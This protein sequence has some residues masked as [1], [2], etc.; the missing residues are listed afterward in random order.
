VRLRVLTLA[1]AAAAFIVGCAPTEGRHL[2]DQQLTEFER[3][4]DETGELADRTERELE[5]D[6]R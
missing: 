5:S 2:D 4:V 3:L 6:P 1:T